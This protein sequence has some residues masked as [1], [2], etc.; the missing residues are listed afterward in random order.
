[1]GTDVTKCNA[2]SLFECIDKGRYDDP[3]DFYLAFHSPPIC[4]VECAGS[5]VCDP[6]H[7]MG[8]LVGGID[9]AEKRRPDHTD[10]AGGPLVQGGDSGICGLS[11]VP[12][13]RYVLSSA[14]RT[15]ELHAGSL[16]WA[17]L[18]FLY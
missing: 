16:C 5:R 14:T 17:L 10:N 3:Q 18:W 7:R 4:I 13:R 11:A 1:V 9:D 8:V 12:S 15:S 2:S 6:G